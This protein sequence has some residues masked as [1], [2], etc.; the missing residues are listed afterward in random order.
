MLDLVFVE[1]GY[2]V[3]DEPRERAAKINEFVHHE[4]HDSSG[5]NIVPHIGIPCCPQALGNVEVCVVLGDLIVLAPVGFWRR[6]EE[7]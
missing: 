3:D 1:V 4:R 7:R 6:G 5:E 2:A